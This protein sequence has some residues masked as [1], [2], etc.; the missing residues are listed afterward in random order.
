MDS[1]K[2]SFSISKSFGTL[3]LIPD[4][5]GLRMNYIPVVNGKLVP[6]A[7]GSCEILIPMEAVGGLWA[8]AKAFLF[9]VESLDENIMLRD[10]LGEVLI[11]LYR[12]RPKGAQGSLSGDEMSWLRIVTGKTE[13]DRRRMKLGPRD[14]ICLEI[15]CNTAMTAS[16]LSAS[17][18]QSQSLV[19]QLETHASVN[20]SRLRTGKI[21]INPSQSELQMMENDHR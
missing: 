13:A 2:I 5:T 1:A 8:T 19:E 21:I 17:M 4:P 16:V 14:L 12:D 15:A 18:Q 20:T 7:I 11:K 10:E 9:G 6:D 3:Q